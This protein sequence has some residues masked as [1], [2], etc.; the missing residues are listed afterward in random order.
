MA[1]VS[2]SFFLSPPPQSRWDRL[3]DRHL[4][5]PASQP[6]GLRKDCISP[7]LDVVHKNPN[8]GTSVDS[9]DTGARSVSSLSTSGHHRAQQGLPP[10]VGHKSQG[11]PTC[12]AQIS[13]PQPTLSYGSKP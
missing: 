2:H 11:G 7:A 6:W 3:G 13:C 9:D 8:L 10:L 1:P 5:P 12:I 4:P